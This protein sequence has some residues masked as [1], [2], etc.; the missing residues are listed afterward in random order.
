MASHTLNSPMVRP[1]FSLEHSG[2]EGK[3]FSPSGANSLSS[4]PLQLPY[5]FFEKPEI[6][7]AIANTVAF[8]HGDSR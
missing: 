2:Y 8:C 6:T 3:V 7:R 4:S 1:G 5:G